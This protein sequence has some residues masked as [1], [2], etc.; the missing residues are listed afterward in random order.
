[1]SFLEG[2]PTENEGTKG[3]CKPIF[4]KQAR[5]GTKTHIDNQRIRRAETTPH[6]GKKNSVI[7]TGKPDTQENRAKKNRG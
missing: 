6:G 3:L 1:M 2:K 5:L 4:L 7:L